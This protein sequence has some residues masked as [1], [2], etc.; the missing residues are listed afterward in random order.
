MLYGSIGPYSLHILLYNTEPDSSSFETQSYDCIYYTYTE[1]SESKDVRQP[2]KY[3]IRTNQSIELTRSFST[4]MNDHDCLQRGKKYDF[5]VLNKMNIIPYDL[6]MWNSGVG[7]VDRYAAYLNNSTDHNNLFICN[8][9]KDGTFGKFCEYELITLLNPKNFENSVRFLLI[10]R[11][12]YLLGSQIYGQIMCYQPSFQCYSGSRCL[13]W[14]DICDGK[15]QCL[16]G[17]DE[18]HCEKLLYN[19][20]DPLTEYPCSNG[21]C[22][23][24]EFFLDG[25]FDCQDASDEQL[26]PTLQCIIRANF[27][28]DE[29]I[30]TR[31]MYFSCGDGDSILDIAVFR[32]DL[33]DGL[34]CYSYRD[35]NFMCELDPYKPMWTMPDGRCLYF[36]SQHPDEDYCSF[37]HKCALTNG[38]SIDCPCIGNQCR[39]NIQ[40]NC[41]LSKFPPYIGQFTKYPLSP[42]YAPFVHTF[43]SITHNYERNKL[44]DIYV[45]NGTIKCVGYQVNA[46]DY[47]ISHTD[48]LQFWGNRAHQSPFEIRYCILGLEIPQLTNDMVGSAMYDRF[49]W[50]NTYS[51]DLIFQCPITN[52][53]LTSY[54]V[55]DNLQNCPTN[56]DEILSSIGD[57]SKIQKYRFK[58]SDKEHACFLPDTIGNGNSDCILSNRDEY[59]VEQ[60]LL[61]STIKC[62]ERNSND[63]K[64]LRKYIEDST[65]SSFVQITN[66]SNELSMIKPLTANKIRFRDYC[67]SFW[68]MNYGYDETLC[69]EWKCP[70]DYFQC[71]TG[72]CIPLKWLC[73]GIWDC[74]DGSDEEAFQLITE[75]TLHNS[76]LISD[77]KL[78]KEECKQVNRIRPFNTFCNSTTEFPCIRSDAIK[79]PFNFTLSK[80][81]IPL[82]KIGDDDIDCLGGID[83]RNKFSCASNEMLGFNYYCQASFL[84]NTSQSHCLSTDRLCKIH[85]PDNEDDFMCFYERYVTNETKLRC[86]NETTIDYTEHLNDFYCLNGTCIPNGK[87]NQRIECEYGEDEY[88][89]ITGPMSN[90][91]QMSR[92][93]MYTDIPQYSLSQSHPILLSDFPKQEKETIVERISNSEDMNL[94]EQ[95]FIMNTSTSQ[96]NPYDKELPPNVLHI[97]NNPLYQSQE[98][99]RKFSEVAWFCNRGITISRTDRFSNKIFLACLCP[100]SYY[101]N[102]CQ[103]YSDRIT[104]F[105]YLD[106]LTDTL[107]S[108]FNITLKILSSFLLNDTVIDTHE[109]HYTPAL[110]N[111]KK[112]HIFYFVYPRPRILS[113]NQFYSVR[114]ELFQLSIM[115]STIDFLAIWKYSIPFDF[116]P[117]YRLVKVLKYKAINQTNHLCKINNPC[118]NNATCYPLMNNDRFYY[119]YCGNTSYG[120]HC[121][122]T[123]NNSS[124]LNHSNNYLCRPNYFN[125][126]PYLIC[127]ANRFGSQ[128]NIER[129]CDLSRGKN[130]CLNNGLCYIDYNPS[131]L[132]NDYICLCSNNK[133]FGENCQY[134]SSII[135][136]HYQNLS[137]LNDEYK[138]IA[139]LIQLSSVI[140]F[141]MIV[142]KQNLYKN[143]L[144][145]GTDIIYDDKAV[146]PIGII[147]FFY[148]QQSSNYREIYFLLYIAENSTSINLTLVLNQQTYCPH[149]SL[150][151]NIDDGTI[152]NQSLNFYND[153]T[154]HSFNSSLFIFKYHLLCDNI[155]QKSSLLCFHDDDYFCFCDVTQHAECFLYDRSVEQCSYCLSGGHCIQG[156]LKMK[157][158]Y[159]CLCPQCYFGSICQHNTKVLSFNL[160]SLITA[161]L[162]SSSILIQ[163]LSISIYL[164]TVISLFLF[165]LINNYF[166]FITF[167]RPRP[168]LIGIGWYLFINS[169]ISQ[170]SLSTLLLKLIY[171]LLGTQSLITN[172][173]LNMILC[174]LISFLLSTSIRMSYWLMG[175]VTIERVYVT[176]YPKREWLKSPRIAKRIIFITTLI[177]F[178]SHIHELI[179]YQIVP[180]PKYTQYGKNIN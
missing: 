163:K 127:S 126:K 46:Q 134:Q 80:P 106:D 107:K 43:Y 95:R 142:Y 135:S 139:S 144:L 65:L 88:F 17:V 30:S 89:C 105:T 27:L 137:F 84:K 28:C 158:D 112:K 12:T 16:N 113:T 76:I 176:M 103:Y 45:F 8:C 121:E 128:C 68:D 118:R 69:K 108:N 70:S 34:L 117:A 123:S 160:E 168:S 3:C 92:Y 32:R 145:T 44:P 71:Q 26:L 85:C 66:S 90:F 25:F 138:I 159:L 21:Q 172:E 141:Q 4:D 59:V 50:N 31:K 83:E 20:C 23:D 101:G 169:I 102:Q 79:N 166:C 146:P 164:I 36:G 53:C 114:F 136:I 179:Y 73:N 18:D 33:V 63:C 6:L 132:P 173:L 120:R 180:D 165:G 109:F 161:D 104:I 35:K 56:H 174:K 98:E 99:Q 67:N 55:R 15:Q 49:C 10:L 48:L 133:Y 110:N 78:K 57:C 153:T 149:T 152:L 170:I 178:S 24:Q 51:N 93:R 9:T 22:I 111:L 177:I 81:C 11:Q 19:E 167:R 2:I 154:Y 39:Q 143:E 40:N 115:N 42:T 54:H 5:K 74:S 130:P 96:H 129:Q 116:L 171:I 60:D 140:N 155:K 58:C 86:D 77:L 61:L 13:D 38:R 125:S 41:P 97:L 14:R 148:K 119:C 37:L 131:Y 151:F 62:T 87:C 175:F 94:N 124:C 47:V 147:K 29:L 157:S 7:L 156:D 64:F 82:S 75:L 72:Q 150:L 1:D 162:F 122:Y 91:P 52:D 100:P